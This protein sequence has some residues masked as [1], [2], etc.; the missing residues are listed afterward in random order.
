MPPIAWT[1]P[2]AEFATKIK[3]IITSEFSNAKL[4]T[5]TDGYMHFEFT[6]RFFRFIDDVEF[7]FD[8]KEAVVQ[9]RSASRVGHSDLGANRRRMNKIKESLNR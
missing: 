7:L 1:G 2:R 4:I 5:E 6:S 3:S 9:F 8:D